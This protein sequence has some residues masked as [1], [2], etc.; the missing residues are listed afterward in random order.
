MRRLPVYILVDTSGSM[1]G[2]PIE[3]V[4]VGLNDMLA[5]LRQDPYALE[6]VWISV[7][8]F[9]REVRQLVPLTALDKLQMPRIEVAESGPTF[10]GQSLE[11]LCQCYDKE[12]VTGS[13]TQKG[14]WMPLLF[15]LTD[16]KP[17]DVQLY[18]KQ[19]ERVK[20]RAFGCIVA[21]AAGPKAKVDPLRLLTMNVYSLDT[22]SGTSFKQFFSWVSTAI[23]QGGKSVGVRGGTD[24]P[25][26]PAEVNIVV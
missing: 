19:V 1:R 17:S 13:A 11:L 6:T 10:T 23:G 21:C 15:L 16:G 7:I 5:M 20:S 12:V 4:R 25:A 9:A 22:L 3:S 8:T 24:L 2:E 26:P 18:D 14:D